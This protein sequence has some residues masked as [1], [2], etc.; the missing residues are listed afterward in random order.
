MT[1]IPPPSS[2]SPTGKA[3]EYAQVRDW[4]KYYQVIAGKPPRQTLLDALT[5]FDADDKADAAKSP[6]PAHGLPRRRLAVDLACGEGRDAVELLKRGWRVIA[7]D[8][9]AQALDILSR[10]LDVDEALN[11][12]MVVASFAQATWPRGIDL[13]NA[14]YALPFCAPEHF[15]SLWSRIV[16]SIKPGGRF[17]GQFF[18]ERD[19]WVSLPEQTHHTRSQV[20]RLFDAFLVESFKEVE[21]DEPTSIGLP[22]HWHLFHIVARKR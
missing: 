6:V 20:E 9:E 3:H 10:R 13:L 19:S 14:S 18:G 2:D 4:A 22:K 16:S 11:V 8:A 21:N 15:D 7:I 17:A 5:A 12:Q 1:D